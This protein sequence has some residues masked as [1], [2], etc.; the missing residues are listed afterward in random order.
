MVDIYNILADKVIVAADSE[1]GYIVTWNGS[2]T[3]EVFA[4]LVDSGK[5]CFQAID[6]F[7]LYDVDRVGIARLKAENH[8]KAMASAV[9][10]D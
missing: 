6:C 2:A 7:T 5:E 3:F 10:D 9:F 1:L 4:E 8:L